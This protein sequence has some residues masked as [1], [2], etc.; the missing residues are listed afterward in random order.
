VLPENL[1]ALYEVAVAAFDSELADFMVPASSIPNTRI[2]VTSDHGE[3]FGDESPDI[4]RHGQPPKY[5]SLTHIP[6]IVSGPPV[7][8]PDALLTLSDIRS[9]VLG[10]KIAGRSEVASEYISYV[11]ADDLF[12]TATIDSFGGHHIEVT[13]FQGVHS[14]QAQLPEDTQKK[15]RALG[16]LD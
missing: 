15:L 16:Y 2:I 10:H 11:H 1:R 7:A 6:L 9:I 14:S 5:P 4:W 12:Y 3:S 8:K 13:R